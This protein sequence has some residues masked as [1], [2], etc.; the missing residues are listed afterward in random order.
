MKK[1]PYFKTF[2]VQDIHYSVYND[3][4]FLETLS[5]EQINGKKYLS[6]VGN[7]ISSRNSFYD[8]VYYMGVV[9]LD[10][11][12]RVGVLLV[13]MTIFLFLLPPV[14]YGMKSSQKKTY[15]DYL[16]YVGL[17][18][19]LALTLKVGYHYATSVYASIGTFF[20]AVFMAYF[21]II[22]SVAASPILLIIMMSMVSFNQKGFELYADGTMF[23]LLIELVK[24]HLL[25]IGIDID[26]DKEMIILGFKLI[27]LVLILKNVRLAINAIFIT[28]SSKV[29]NSFYVVSVLALFLS[30]YYFNQELMNRFASFALELTKTI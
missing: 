7:N 10:S 16:V 18:I 13:P 28:A 12:L 22:I 11:I 4:A 1:E 5:Y 2:H 30:L 24:I 3:N 19:A 20:Q 26:V 6:A 15:K 23:E 25:N 14:I 9:V 8:K 17:F 29:Q 21:M 27:L